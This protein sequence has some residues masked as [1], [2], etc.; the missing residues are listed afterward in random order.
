MNFPDSDSVK[1][2]FVGDSGVGKT[3]IIS[4]YTH[5]S[6]DPKSISTMA[7]SYTQKIIKKNNR[8]I[9]LDIWD[10]AGQERYHALGK[11]FYKNSYIVCL[12]YDIT[13]LESFQNVKD[14]WYKDIKTYGEEDIILA[15]VGNKCDCYE[16]ENVSDNDAKKFAD[17]VGAIF[18]LTSAKSGI[19][20][21]LLF[22][23]VMNAYLNPE[24]ESR[25]EAK[26]NSTISINN[27]ALSNG[28]KGNKNNKKEEEAGCC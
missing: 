1:I 5:D 7:V 23:K 3:C 8:N 12:V 21:N 14:I 9:K 25:I 18:Q 24:F 2:T 15:I 6:F 13:R 28:K 17:D 27:S 11:H 19:G 20:I 4:R 22:K 16:Q 26:K 10:T